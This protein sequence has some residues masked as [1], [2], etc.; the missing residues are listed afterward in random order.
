MSAYNP[1]QYHV[2]LFDRIGSRTG[3]LAAESFTAAMAAGEQ[4]RQAG[5]CHSFVVLRVLH[6]SMM[7]NMENYDVK[8]FWVAINAELTGGE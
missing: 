7:P 2:L 8:T 5:E 6:N 4:A 1:G 3:K